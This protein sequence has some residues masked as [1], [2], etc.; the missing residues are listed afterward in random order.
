MMEHNYEWFSR[1]I[2]GE[3]PQV[4]AGSNGMWG[5]YTF[6]VALYTREI[7]EAS[8]FATKCRACFHCTRSTAALSKAAGRGHASRLD[9][10]TVKPC[11]RERSHSLR[12]PLNKI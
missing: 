6:Y 8:H 12:G 3:E 5:L 11:V 10:T 4:S 9:G 2:W 1:Y 7:G